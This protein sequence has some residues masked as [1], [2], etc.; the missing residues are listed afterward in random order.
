MQIVCRGEDLHEMSTF[1]GEKKSKEISSAPVVNDL[2]VNI[3]TYNEGPDH[4]YCIYLKYSDILFSKR[5]VKRIAHKITKIRDS[6]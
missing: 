6:V 4:L 5:K 2:W 1:L 3:N